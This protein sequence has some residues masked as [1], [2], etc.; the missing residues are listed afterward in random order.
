MTQPTD[1]K[2]V[3]NSFSMGD[4][5]KLIAEVV[6]TAI[7]KS[8]A[9][10]VEKPAEGEGKSVGIAAVV[11]AE[12]DKIKADEKEEN[13]KKTI[14]EKLAEL[15]EKTQEKQP[16]ERRRVHKMMGWGEND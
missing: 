15:S 10:V 14:Q 4:L 6:S 3:G 8:E 5:K 11:K 12:I 9:P 7:P 1:D 2:K 13:D 16:I